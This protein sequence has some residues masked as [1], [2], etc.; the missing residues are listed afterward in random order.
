[1][2]AE[3]PASLRESTNTVV[4]ARAPRRG[5]PASDQ[6]NVADPGSLVQVDSSSKP[7]VHAGTRDVAEPLVERPS[8]TATAPVEPSA[9][10]LVKEPVHSQGEPVESMTQHEQDSGPQRAAAAA[11]IAS[12]DVVLEDSKVEAPRAVLEDSKVETPRAVLED[13]K[14]E[15][16]RAVMEDSKVEA[17]R[18]VLVDWDG[19]S[20]R[21]CWSD[22]VLEGRCS[23]IHDMA[24]SVSFEGSRGASSKVG[25]AVGE[26]GFETW[27]MGGRARVV[28]EGVFPSRLVWGMPDAF[29]AAVSGV[30][31]TMT[32]RLRQFDDADAGESTSV[33]FFPSFDT[34]EPH[35]GL[36]E[37]ADELDGELSKYPLCQVMH[38]IVHK[39]TRRGEL[40]P[41]LV[42][43]CLPSSI[44]HRDDHA[45]IVLAICQAAPVNPG[46]VHITSRVL[47]TVAS[48]CPRAGEGGTVSER[49]GG[50]CGVGVVV[51]AM[52]A[53]VAA[54]HSGFTVTTRGSAEEDGAAWKE[55]LGVS[56]GGAS[57]VDDSLGGWDVDHDQIKQRHDAGMIQLAKYGWKA[58]E[59]ALGRV[60]TEPVVLSFASEGALSAAEDLLDAAV[61]SASMACTTGVSLMERMVPGRAEVSTLSGGMN[62][63]VA[64]VLARCAQ[65]WP[66][67]GEDIQTLASPATVETLRRQLMRVY[68]KEETSEAGVAWS[69]SL[70][71]DI[72]DSLRATL[73]D[74]FEQL[75][76]MS[77]QAQDSSSSSKTAFRG[78]GLDPAAASD[79]VEA[80]VSLRAAT[81]QVLR[82]SNE[83]VPQLS[84]GKILP[85]IQRWLA[86]NSPTRDEQIP[87]DITPEQLA[88]H[89]QQLWYSSLLSTSSGTS[90]RCG[91][92]LGYLLRHE[93]P[94]SGPSTDA[95]TDS[96]VSNHDTVWADSIIA[97]WAGL[98]VGFKDI[99]GTLLALHEKSLPPSLIAPASIASLVRAVA[100]VR[101][102]LDLDVRDECFRRITLGGGWL[103][104]ALPAAM[105]SLLL[106]QTYPTAVVESEASARSLIE[107]QLRGMAR[108]ALCLSGSDLTYCWDHLKASSEAWT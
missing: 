76:T 86:G 92:L 31:S 21:A 93:R 68:S 62:I 25:E 47:A 88:S 34:T 5:S 98:Q 65:V 58:T 102:R 22:E 84:M 106:A 36:W 7:F 101:L 13:S 37:A 75:A 11:A 20:V 41:D 29:D 24:S 89:S 19:W 83:Q 78:V 28:E 50:V 1:V 64:R 72:L 103:R 39:I 66:R 55:R 32:V 33:P 40:V 46:L 6:E 26:R 9:A 90:L 80:I 107:A 81:E 44:S 16:P 43:V 73:G 56:L 30:E 105:T 2:A 8:T 63:L 97:S 74:D 100:L 104:A 15:A 10:A 79:L 52:S 18:A 14:V 45:R 99:H 77:S 94:R 95:A 12:E 71:E 85:S 51:N 3:G 96:G 87:R 35:E 60:A 67:V 48:A 27:T 53:D 70:P 82:W 59:S 69:G 61:A 91:E 54:V 49:L 57:A 38:H 4:E 108:L 23:H 17:P 42:L